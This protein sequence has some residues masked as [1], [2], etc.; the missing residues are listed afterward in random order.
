MH[1]PRSSRSSK[2]SPRAGAVASLALADMRHEWLLN[3]C[4]VLALAGI[5]SPLLLLFGLKHGV[6]EVLRSQLVQ[7]PVYRE[8]KPAQTE[9]LDPT[10]FERM[11][12]RPDVAFVLPTILRGSSIVRAQPGPG[13][14]GADGGGAESHALDLIPTAGGDPLFLDT[15]TPIPGRGEAALSQPAA[16]LL[17]LGPGDPLTVSVSR[18]RDGRVQQAEQVLTVVGVLPIKADGLERIYTPLAL[19]VDVEAYR[20]GMAVPER[21]WP[22]GTPTPTPRIDGAYVFLDEPL[23]PVVRQSLVIGTGFLTVNRVQ[24]ADVAARLGLAPKDSGAIY[25]VSVLR[26][27][28]PPSSVRNLRAPLRGR[29][30]VIVPFIRDLTLRIGPTEVPAA[31]LS[32]TDQEADQLG[33][34]RLPWQ[35]R[36]SLGSNDGLRQVLVPPDLLDPLP[37]AGATVRA[38]GLGTAAPL[39]FPL[40]VAGT[41]PGAVALIPAELAGTLRAASERAVSYDAE[42]DAF[43]L[44]KAEF[45]GFRLYAKR[46]EDVPGLYRAMQEQDIPVIAQV[47]EIERIR[48]LDRGL[49]AVFWLIAVVGIVGGIASLISNLYAAVERKTRDLSMMRLMGLPRGSVFLFPIVQSL[50]VA[51]A[52]SLVALAAYGTLATVINTVFADDLAFAGA[53]DQNICELPLVVLGIAVAATVAASVVSA[54]GAAWRTTRIEPGE[55][56]RV[57]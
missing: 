48:I 43:L 5:L 10:W 2:A 31:G 57:E 42:R 51:L 49:T 55:A 36:G 32:L 44:T 35:D 21:G 38:E 28:V 34:P 6:I 13:D 47:E 22:G 40:D 53:A 45:R 27:P 18:S 7:D 41:A 56:I 25:E 8:L 29:G 4:I 20:E 9:S 33:L 15:N 14:A 16:E 11:G 46:I 30:A 23:N 3:L 50:V 17:G 12:A 1:A 26:N 37:E 39:R 54:L 24:P 52:C 19:A